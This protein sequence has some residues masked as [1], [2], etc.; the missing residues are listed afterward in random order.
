MHICVDQRRNV[1]LQRIFKLHAIFDVVVGKAEPVLRCRAIGF[2]QI[3]KALDR[4]ETY[5]RFRDFKA[6]HIEQAKGFKA[7]LAN[8][9]SFRTK[10]RLSK[11]TLYATLTSSQIDLAD[12][13]L[14]E[15]GASPVLGLGVTVAWT[16]LRPTSHAAVVGSA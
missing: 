15:T 8:Q 1:V 4:F 11:A 3:D 13:P 5:T 7:S 16:A 12:S 10:D 9:T 2:A 6:F 14:H